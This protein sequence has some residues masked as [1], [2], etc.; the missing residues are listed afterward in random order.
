MTYRPADKWI[1]I[2][3]VVMLG[4]A[5]VGLIAFIARLAVLGHP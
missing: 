2:V 5:F 4:L 3:A 1:G